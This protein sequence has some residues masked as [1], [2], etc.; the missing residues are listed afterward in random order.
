MR[1]KK[2]SKHA[3]S[4]TRS[5]TLRASTVKKKGASLRRRVN[6]TLPGVQRCGSPLAGF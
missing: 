1:N 6:D 5:K 2:V 3:Y 4:D